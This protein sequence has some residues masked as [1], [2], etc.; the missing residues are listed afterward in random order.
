MTVNYNWLVKAALLSSRVEFE[1]NFE[2]LLLIS[3][4][5]YGHNAR[6]L[7]LKAVLSY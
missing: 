3:S 1:S 7:L 6:P 4:K 2:P 5:S